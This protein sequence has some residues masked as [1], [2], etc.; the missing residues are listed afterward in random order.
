MTRNNNPPGEPFPPTS[1]K[2]V[3]NRLPTKW[4]LVI[5][6]AVVLTGWLLNTPPGWMGKSDAVGYAICHQI[7]ERSLNVPVTPNQILSLG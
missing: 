5:V 2:T 6:L 7:F 4:L 1:K 3:F